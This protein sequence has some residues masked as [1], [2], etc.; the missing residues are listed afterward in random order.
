MRTFTDH[1]IDGRQVAIIMSRKNEERLSTRCFRGAG[2]ALAGNFANW[3]NA[4]ELFGDGKV[5]SALLEKV[6]AAIRNRTYELSTDFDLGEFVG[7]SSTDDLDIYDPR[8]LSVFR[9]NK[10]AI[11]SMVAWNYSAPRTNHLTVSCSIR[12]NENPA[13][14]VVIIHTVYPGRNVGVLVGDV[15]RRENVVFFPWDR[16][17]G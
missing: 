17:G 12:L 2:R 1:Y 10:R 15:S 11:G 8:H 4:Y 6:E 16:V 14:V 5:A 3:S 7:W 9:I 13:E